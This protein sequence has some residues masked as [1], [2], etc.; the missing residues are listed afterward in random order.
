[1]PN[2]ESAAKLCE[3]HNKM[4]TTRATSPRFKSPSPRL[5]SP[6]FIQSSPRPAR[7]AIVQISTSGAPLKR[8]ISS[9][10]SMAHR[11]GSKSFASNRVREGANSEEAVGTS[12]PANQVRRAE[13]QIGR[14]GA[15]TGAMWWTRPFLQD[16]EKSPLATLSS[17]ASAFFPQSGDKRRD[18]RI[19]TTTLTQPEP[20]RTAQGPHISCEMVLEAHTAHGIREPGV[21]KGP[22]VADAATSL[23]QRNTPVKGGLMQSKADWVCAQAGEPSASLPKASEP[24][25]PGRAKAADGAIKTSPEA[26]KVDV[27]EK[28]Q[29]QQVGET[30]TQSAQPRDAQRASRQEADEREEERRRQEETRLAL[31]REKQEAEKMEFDRKERERK[32][33]QHKRVQEL[34]SRARLKGSSCAEALSSSVGG[35]AAPVAVAQILSISPSPVKSPVSEPARAAQAD[36]HSGRHNGRQ[37]PG[38]C[39]LGG[40]RGVSH[41]PPPPQIHP[42]VRHLQTLHRV[43]DYQALASVQGSQDEGARMRTGAERAVAKAERLSD[44]DAAKVAE[45]VRAARAALTRESAPPQ[46][47]QFD[48]SSVAQQARAA[49]AQLEKKRAQSQVPSVGVG[50]RE[51]KRDGQAKARPVNAPPPDLKLHPFTVDA[52]FAEP[53]GAPYRAPVSPPQSE[54][55]ASQASPDINKEKGLTRDEE[56]RA[57]EAYGIREAT[58]KRSAPGSSPPKPTNT[59]TANSPDAPLYLLGNLCAV[60]EAEEEAEE[61]EEEGLVVSCWVLFQPRDSADDAQEGADARSERSASVEALTFEEF[62]WQVRRYNSHQSALQPHVDEPAP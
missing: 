16:A 58:P 43:S 4:E 39:E 28:K 13:T 36:G 33:E 25:D 40:W 35:L 31:R 30:P 20:L 37:S 38:L 62:Y 29:L 9:Q 48:A 22:E 11:V 15:G 60:A 10:Q 57:Y 49:K 1:M 2:I 6:R 32:A 12:N 8:A 19:R 24:K 14:S 7:K 55:Q 21:G 26:H 52:V 51:A 41:K 42:S 44:M 46:K 61:E 53:K 3:K 27:A 59:S 47:T 54:N 17:T 5:K 56:A 50:E 23:S 34:L 18:P 45:Q